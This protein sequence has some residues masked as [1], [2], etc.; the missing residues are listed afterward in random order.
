VIDRDGALV[1]VNSEDD[2][3]HR[4]ELDIRPPG[5]WLEELKS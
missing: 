3:L 4:T 5:N 1:G 2:F